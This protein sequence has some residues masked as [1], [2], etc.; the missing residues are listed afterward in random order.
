VAAIGSIAFLLLGQM[1]RRGATTRLSIQLGAAFGLTLASKEN[2][3][4]ILPVMWAWPL[5][6]S[7]RQ[8]GGP[9]WR[10]ALWPVARTG[11]IVGAI[12]AVVGGWWFVR[13][14]VVYGAP[15][16]RELSGFTELP[17]S[18][19]SPLRIVEAAAMYN[20]TF[21]GSFGW[22]LLFLPTSWNV[23]LGVLL[24]FMLIG[25]ATALWRERG[26]PRFGALLWLLAAVLLVVAATEFRRQLSP[27]PGRDHARY[28]LPAI[29]PLSLLL[30]LG[31]VDLAG[32]L[33]LRALPGLV[34]AG[35]AAL[36]VATP[37][38]VIR[39][40]FP[41]PVAVRPSI[42]RWPIQQR[43]AADFGGVVRL[44]GYD[45]PERGASGQTLEV[46]L[47]WEMLDRATVDHAA[48]VHLVDA[49]G[50]RVAQA[51]GPIGTFAYGT[52][53]LLVG[54]AAQTRHPIRLPDGLEPGRYTLVVGVYPS[55]AADARLPVA[56]RALGV[57][58]NAVRLA[59]VELPGAVEGRQPR[60]V[61]YGGVL[62]LAGVRLPAA[63]RSGASLDVD[64]E[65]E[66]LG[67]V[68]RDYQVFVHL[69]DGADRPRA[70]SDGPLEIAAYPVSR[71]QPGEL[72]RVRRSLQLDAGYPPGQYRL[73]VGLYDPK[74]PDQRLPITTSDVQSAAQA[75][76]IGQVEV[77][78]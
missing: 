47:Y 5:W 14:T 13:N 1:W 20:A 74:Q 24:L 8:R 34:G 12:T 25:V 50:A 10:G 3:L 23:A 49:A 67:P 37:V 48:F 61:V 15:I 57:A 59:S 45:A 46:A 39:P 22:Q 27:Q 65:W 2:A 9:D 73:L 26:T 64:L 6:L 78:P 53:R 4:A 29:A 16:Q 77:R 11:L 60:D 43:T 56:G 44:A 30:W 7:W 18:A 62:K 28:W 40:S 33:R 21:W 76:W 32:R 31:L 63:A 72:I 68:G 58:S 17:L 51:D 69:V 75:A 66:T 36:A 41:E 35:L 71:W 52:S 55:Q 70:Q 38:L 42:A 54:E 19:L